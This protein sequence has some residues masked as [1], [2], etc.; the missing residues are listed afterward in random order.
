[1]VNSINSGLSKK[2]ARIYKEVYG[3]FPPDTGKPELRY[4]RRSWIFP[5]H[6]DIMLEIIKK[7]C[8]KYGGDEEICSL[9]AVLH[10]TGLVYGRTTASPKGHEER[11][12]EYAKILLA[13]YDYNDKVIKE[14]LNCI[15]VTDSEV[16]PDNI[17][18]KIVRTADALSKFISCHFIAKAV[19]STSIDEY[20]K[21]LDKKLESSYKKICFEDERKEAEPAYK[22]LM[23][24]VISY[25]DK[26]TI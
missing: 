8:P 6:F 20:M 5:Q 13:K 4:V 10:D 22:Y 18:E 26:A 11:S 23:Q 17:N 24:T 14:V 2:F 7:L 12:V 9:A 15:N 1:M 21:W 25:K 3:L 19:F 16:T